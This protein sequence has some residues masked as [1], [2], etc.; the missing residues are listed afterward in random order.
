MSKSADSSHTQHAQIA[1][2]AN[3][4]ELQLQTVPSC[5]HKGQGL[6]EHWKALGGDA[7]FRRYFRLPPDIVVSGKKLLA[8]WSPPATEQND[9]FI[10]KGKYLF[11]CGISSPE[12]FFHDGEQGFFLLEDFGERMLFDVLN[13]ENVNALYGEAFKELVKLQE[14][15]AKRGI[16]GDYNGAEL[17][18]E[19]QVFDE[20]FVGALLG[21]PLSLGEQKMLQQFYRSLCD[22][23]LEQPQAIVHRDF[24]SRNLVYRPEQPLGVIDFQDALIGPFTYDLVSLLRDCYVEWPQERVDEWLKVY[25]RLPH[26]QH[27]GA[28][29]AQFVRWFDWMGLQRHIKVLGVFSRLHLRDNKPAYLNDLPLVLSY[30]RSVVKRYAEL[31]EFGGWL[32]NRLVPIINE[33]DWMNSPC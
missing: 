15:P 9:A 27:T 26:V 30:V 6:A 12:V 21:S 29:E 16:F 11:S 31:A 18:R 7:G 1:K 2:L 14:S 4:A 33:Q 5:M 19:L 10:A 25:W 20:W 17:L 8:V 28:S 32:E 22:S 3:W 24:H 23:A 13:A